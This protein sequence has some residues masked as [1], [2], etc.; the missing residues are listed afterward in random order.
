MEDKRFE[1]A[2]NITVELR[3]EIVS[4]QKVRAQIIGFKITFV[5]TAIGLVLAYMG[6]ISNLTL[7]VPAFSAIFFDLLINSYSFGIKR[8]GYYC[9][10]YLEPE[11]RRGSDWPENS[12]L[13]EQFMARPETIQRYSTFGNIGITILALIPALWSIL[14]PFKPLLSSV[15]IILILVFFIFDIYSFLHPKRIASKGMNIKIPG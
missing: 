13:F 1:F 2:W 14:N 15:F 3:K 11:L 12:L 4:L 9:R 8:L 7:M 5:G 6:D 10:T